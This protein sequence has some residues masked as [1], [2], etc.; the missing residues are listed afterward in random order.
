MILNISIFLAM[1]LAVI[2]RAVADGSR[3]LEHESQIAFIKKKLSR[4]WHRVS[5]AADVLLI[6]AMY[7]FSTIW[8][9]IPGTTLK[10]N[11]ID[12]AINLLIYVALR[13]AL[14]NYAYNIAAK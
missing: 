12:L 7:L 13:Y 4:R 14:F 8:A 2:A 10:D 11:L 5:V 3:S 6:V 9:C 1:S